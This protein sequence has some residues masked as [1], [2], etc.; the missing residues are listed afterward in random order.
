MD[1][2]IAHIEELSKLS[3]YIKMYRN[4]RHCRRNMMILKP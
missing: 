3:P 1:E 2:I 4:L